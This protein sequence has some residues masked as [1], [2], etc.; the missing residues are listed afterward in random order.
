MKSQGH[1][2]TPSFV[3]PRSR[4][5]DGQHDDAGVN[6]GAGSVPGEAKI[7]VSCLLPFTIHS[8]S[9]RVND[10]D[11]PPYPPGVVD[12]R[13]GSAPGLSVVDGQ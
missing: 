8:P 10:N 6:S 1:L 4:L 3:D 7:D 11:L 5:S 13:A 2:G 9:K 12:S